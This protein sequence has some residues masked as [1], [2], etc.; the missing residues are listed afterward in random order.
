MR[1][2]VHACP[3]G[4]YGAGTIPRRI[5]GVA[6]LIWDIATHAKVPFWTLGLHDKKAGGEKRCNKEFEL[7]Y[8]TLCE[9]DII[10]YNRE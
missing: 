9:V 4:E 5:F 8:N 2:Q 3:Y 7:Y 1:P 6:S 10:P